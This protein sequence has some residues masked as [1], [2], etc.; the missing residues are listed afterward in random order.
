LSVAQ[1][2]KNI[3]KKEKVRRQI[4]AYSQQIKQIA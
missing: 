4:S 1:K 3:G 2:I